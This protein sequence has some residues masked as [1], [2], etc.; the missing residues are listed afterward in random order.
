MVT[1][2]LPSSFRNKKN[3]EQE[4]ADEEDTA[5]YTYITY[6]KTYLPEKWSRV[7]ESVLK[8]DNISR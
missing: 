3:Q 8:K 2:A 6:E 4:K 7:A 1:L 5:S